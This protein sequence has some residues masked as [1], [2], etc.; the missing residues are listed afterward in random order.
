M[1]SITYDWWS[2]ELADG[3]VVKYLYGT[4]SGGGGVKRSWA[5]ATVSGAD[6]ETIQDVAVGL[7]RS[8]VEALFDKLS[9]PS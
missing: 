2:K 6:A 5:S 4:F 8:A 9:A 1:G 7:S 3:R